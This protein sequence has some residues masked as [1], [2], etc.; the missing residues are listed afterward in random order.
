MPD[1]DLAYAN[2]AFIPGSERLPG[3]WAAQA[4]TFRGRVPG[5]LG[6]A[7]GLA[8]RQKFD[9]FLPQET[10]LGL[11]VFVHGGY[12]LEFGRDSWSHLAAGT[13]A[14]GWACAMPSYTLAPDARISQ[15]TQEIA[16]AVR[17]AAAMVEGPVVVTGHS[18]GGHL[19]A[20]MGCA[21]L[22][23]DIVRR[24]VPISPIADL[25]PLMQT[26]MQKGLRL[27]EAE[28][29]SESPARLALR[30]GCL[31]HVWVGA[32]ERPAFLWQARLLS[33]EWDCP[34]TPYPDRN[35]FSVIDD[36][37]DPDSALL[38]VCLADF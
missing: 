26:A 9:L 13:L 18:A 15:I 12:W 33:E 25:A 36:L 8:E 16:T 11:L 34:W 1:M 20:R 10:P 29:A 17:A 21:D 37:A 23:L 19:A 4:A 35:H 38:Q 2:G 32:Q 5:R 28:C 27:T 30:D 7:Y 22:A 3:L 31:A 6:L 24:V 14:R